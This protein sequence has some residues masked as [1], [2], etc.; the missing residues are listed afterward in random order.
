MQEGEKGLLKTHLERGSQSVCA[1]ASLSH[2]LQVLVVGG[3]S[4]DIEWEVELLSREGNPKAA[5]LT[6]ADHRSAFLFWGLY[7]DDRNGTVSS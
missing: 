2:S 7:P 4:G 5:S 1:C 3:P 6:T